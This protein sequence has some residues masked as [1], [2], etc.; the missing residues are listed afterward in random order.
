[1]FLNVTF[2]SLWV[3][4]IYLLSRI[5]NGLWFQVTLVTFIWV[6]VLR[7]DLLIHTLIYAGYWK[8]SISVF[9]GKAQRNPISQHL[10]CGQFVFVFNSGAVHG[11]GTSSKV[12]WDR[13]HLSLGK[14][15]TSDLDVIDCLYR[16]C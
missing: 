1:M 6:W 7:F 9:C 12:T 15:R 2:S 4:P 8:R 3:L 13:D 11:S 10:H 5:V 16:L 14:K